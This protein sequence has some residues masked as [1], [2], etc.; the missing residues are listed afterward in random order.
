MKQ[1][2][3]A[4]FT[5]CIV[6]LVGLILGMIANQRQQTYTKVK[7]ATNSAVAVSSHTSALS[8][9][10][11]ALTEQEVIGVWVNHHNKEIHQKITFTADHQWQ[12]N[13]H[14]VANIYSG[15]WKLV[16]HHEISLAPYGEIIR[17]SGKRFKTMNV[18]N[19]HHILT[20]QS[21]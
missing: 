11:K 20:K 4:V 15:T 9:N 18:L 10:Q 16:G 8:V 2:Y 12:E 19:Y 7:P 13:Q 3:L 1:R 5:G 14:H 6:I 17:L 21:D